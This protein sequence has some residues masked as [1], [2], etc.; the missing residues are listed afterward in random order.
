[1]GRGGGE[2]S[3][4]PSDLEER[5][6]KPIYPNP[7]KNEG[8][9]NEGSN[10]TAI[11][12]WAIQLSHAEK[13]EEASRYSADSLGEQNQRL[14]TRQA[15]SQPQET[16]H[17]APAPTPHL[18]TKR[19]TCVRADHVSVEEHCGTQRGHGSVTSEIPSYL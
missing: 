17:C 15:H 16:R 18:Q 11:P 4:R 14:P 7:Q 8:S 6:S 9:A 10:I 2:T 19:P 1:M 12:I 5:N 13:M 3:Y